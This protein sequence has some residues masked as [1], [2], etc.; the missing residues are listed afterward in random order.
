MWQCHKDIRPVPVDPGE[1]FDE[2]CYEPWVRH[3][4]W[5]RGVPDPELNTLEGLP[6]SFYFC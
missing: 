3:R 4:G 5:T 6:Y 2:R 1:E